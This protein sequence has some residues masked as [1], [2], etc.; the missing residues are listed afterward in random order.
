MALAVCLLPDE[1]GEALMRGLWARLEDDGIAT[2]QTHTHK[3]HVPHLTYASLRT[4]DEDRVADALAALPEAEPLALHVD[5]LGMF[6]RSRCWLAPAASVDLVARQEAVVGAAVGT[7]ADLHRHYRPGDWIPHLTLAPR[8]HTTDL[9]VVAR[10]V[11]EVLPLTA[12]VTRAA[13][14]ETA[15]GARHPLDHLV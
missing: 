9:P 3:R 13:L 5:A 1:R 11:Y 2:L 10:I 12:V 15:T 4:Y 6:R 14:I 7:G 8:L